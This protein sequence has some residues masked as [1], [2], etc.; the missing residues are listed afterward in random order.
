LPSFETL[1]YAIFLNN[2]FTNIRLFKALKAMRIGA[3]ETTK[4]GCGFP[5]DLLQLR[6]AATKNKDW[7]KK[8]LTTIKADKI[9]EDEDIL[10]M[11]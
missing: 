1:K 6:A 2:F 4:S 10:C 8:A 3:C 9:I 11:A 7:G 5:I